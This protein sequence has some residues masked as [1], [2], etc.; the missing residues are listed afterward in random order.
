MIFGF[1]VRL[2]NKI[3]ILFSF[4][5]KVDILN[6]AKNKFPEKFNTLAYLI[7]YP[8]NFVGEIIPL[9]GKK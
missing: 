4:R 6:K 8:V 7:F 5:L 9:Q 2:G 3:E 1:S